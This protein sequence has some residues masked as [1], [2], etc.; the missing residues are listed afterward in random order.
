MREWT[1]VYLL[2]SL[3]LTSKST[4]MTANTILSILRIW[5]FQIAGSIAFA[6]AAEEANPGLLEPVMNVSITVPEQF[7]GSIIGDLNGRRGQVM[8]VE[9][10]GRKQVIQANV[11]LSEMLRYSIDLKSMTSARGNFIMEFSHYDIAP[12]DV[13]QKVI[14]ESKQ[15]AEE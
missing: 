12:D 11:P 15:E 14:A 6:A 3:S 10:I 9:Q 1:E 13:A 4:Y 7:M 8:G 2:A 5:R